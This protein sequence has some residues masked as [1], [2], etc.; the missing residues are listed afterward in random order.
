MSENPKNKTNKQRTTTTTTKVGQERKSHKQIKTW[1]KPSV[2]I[3]SFPL[4]YFLPLVSV[5]LKVALRTLEKRIRHRYMTRIDQWHTHICPYFQFVRTILQW[6]IC[7]NLDMQL[8]II[9]ARTIYVKHDHSF[10]LFI[11]NC[12]LYSLKHRYK[13]HTW[14]STESRSNHSSTIK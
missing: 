11:V 8:S 13:I 5:E 6:K 14:E 9:K 4:G 1:H 3:E 10:F 2:G 7:K 12:A